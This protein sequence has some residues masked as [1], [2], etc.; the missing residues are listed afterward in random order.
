[1]NTNAS[2]S[3]PDFCPVCGT[4]VA[5]EAT[6][7]ERRRGEASPCPH[8]G[9]MLWFVSRQVDDVTVVQ[10]IDSRVA[11]MELLDLLDHAVEDGLLNARLLINFGSL[12]QVSSAA[13]G[14]LVKLMGKAGALRGH[15]KLCGLHADLRHVFRITRLD[16]I[17]EVYE[18]EPEGLASFMA[19][20][21]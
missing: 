6:S 8:C 9:H 11:M 19:T 17:F 4:Q 3:K 16:K 15:L 1:M 13:L 20:H 21:A 14:K 5:D 7:D 10:L 2:D 18:T 12:Q